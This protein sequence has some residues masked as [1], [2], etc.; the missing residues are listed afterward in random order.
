MLRVGQMALAHYLHRHEH[1]PLRT[2]ITLFWDNS[3]LPFSIQ[4]LTNVSAR[5]YPHKQKYE[6]YNPCEMG[7]IIKELLDQNLPHVSTK[8][9]LDNSIFLEE[10]PRDR[11]KLLVMIM[12]RIGLDEPESSYLPVLEGFMQSK[13]FMCA[14]GGTPKH[15]HLFL[16]VADNKV[17][18]LDPHKTTRA[19]A[20]E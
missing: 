13:Y 3:D 4:M 17:G 2:I 9:F 20:S 10:I 19:A 12:I 15:A 5:L 11:P 14:L 1:M 8:I 16:Q 6:W 18:F 7:F